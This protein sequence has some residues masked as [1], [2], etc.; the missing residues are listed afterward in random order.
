M[1]DDNSGAPFYMPKEEG[2]MTIEK[3]SAAFDEAQEQ[4]WKLQR[5]GIFQCIEW[6]GVVAMLQKAIMRF[7]KDNK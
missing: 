6:Q 1:T 2:K 7:I 5:D 3:L 4:I